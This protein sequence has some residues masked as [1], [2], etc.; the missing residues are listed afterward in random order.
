MITLSHH[1]FQLFLFRVKKSLR[2]INAEVYRD[3]FINETL[4]SLNYSLLRKLKSEKER[5][6]KNNLANS[7]VVY[8]YQ[9]KYFFCEKRELVHNE[10]T[11]HIATSSCLRQFHYHL[12]TSLTAEQRAS[13]TSRRPESGLAHIPPL[14]PAEPKANT[15]EQ[16]EYQSVPPAHNT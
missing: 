1:R 16:G 4:T 12:D 2:I 7:Q 8:T 11:T 9:G 14:S 3:F 6:N 15:P 5:R 13:T 10:G